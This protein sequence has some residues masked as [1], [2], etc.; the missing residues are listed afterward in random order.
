MAPRWL[1]PA[2]PTKSQ[3]FLADGRWSN[4]VFN[5]VVVDLQMAIFQEHRQCLALSQGIV[6]ALA[7]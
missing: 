2:S 3:F 6:N 5:Q 7:A 1:A 4:G